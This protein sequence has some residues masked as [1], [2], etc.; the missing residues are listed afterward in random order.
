MKNLKKLI[1]N[2]MDHN[3]SFTVHP[4]ILTIEI[5]TKVAS[6]APDIMEMGKKFG[7]KSESQVTVD[8]VALR[9]HTIVTLTF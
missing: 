6:S 9:T 8:N 4:A 3:Y 1:A 2:L 7:S 5:I